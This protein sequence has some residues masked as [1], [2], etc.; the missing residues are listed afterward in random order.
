VLV[1]QAEEESFDETWRL[2]EPDYRPLHY[3]G[4]DR[5]A[6]LG[7]RLTAELR[8]SDEGAIELG[9]TQEDREL[10]EEAEAME[11]ERRKREGEEEEA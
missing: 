11:R 10:R 5:Y 4:L 2:E 9:E 1:V 6:T 7:S 8:T 3:L